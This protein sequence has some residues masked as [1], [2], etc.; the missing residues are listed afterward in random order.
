MPELYLNTLLFS[1]ILLIFIFGWLAVFALSTPE[2]FI[3][4]LSPIYWV[5]RKLF[6]NS[7]HRVDRWIAYLSL[8]FT[9]GGVILISFSLGGW[10]ATFILNLW[11]SPFARVLE[12]F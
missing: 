8:L 3:R 2:E 1:L 5:T 9:L 4:W 10:A 12:D 11:T 6:R 7:F